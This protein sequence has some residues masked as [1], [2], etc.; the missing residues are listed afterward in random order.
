MRAGH[1]GK[2][3]ENHRHERCHRRP[4][5]DADAT[6]RPLGEIRRRFAD[7]L[8]QPAHRADAVLDLIESVVNLGGRQLDTGAKIELIG[9]EGPGESPLRASDRELGELS[10]LLPPELKREP[11][12]GRNAILT[13][14]A[15]LQELVDF[16]LINE[17]ATRFS[18]GA[19]NLLTGNF[20]Y[21]DN[22]DEDIQPAATVNVRCRYVRRSRNVLT[23]DLFGER[24][25]R[26]LANPAHRI[27]LTLAIHHIGET[28]FIEI[29]D[30]EMSDQRPAK[31]R[32]RRADCA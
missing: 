5:D 4:R 27:F 9:A 13:I 18:V 10:R 15:T 19:V 32:P 30:L 31:Y 26:R 29:D 1:R 14:D 3:L 25:A 20:I 22:R 28:V 2:R 7:P 23:D 11:V 21:F 6:T 17:R 12:P 24:T 16:S 8:L